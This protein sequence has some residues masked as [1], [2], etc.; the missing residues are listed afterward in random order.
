M[1][2]PRTTLTDTRFAEMQAHLGG[3]RQFVRA[4]APLPVICAWCPT[5]DKT[6][7]RNAG[8]SHTICPSC[9]AKL[10]QEGL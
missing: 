4:I 5:F 2:T 8:A 9:F 3:R 10:A 6:D 1:D 7:R